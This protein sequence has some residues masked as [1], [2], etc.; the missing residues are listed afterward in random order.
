MI[1]LYKMEANLCCVVY[2]E[3]SHTHIRMLNVRC[4]SSDALSSNRDDLLV[5]DGGKPVL[6]GIWY[7]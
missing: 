5:Q 3:N 2:I 1:S 4:Y 7:I 6:C